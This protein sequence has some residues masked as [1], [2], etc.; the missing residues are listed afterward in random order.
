MLIIAAGRIV[1]SVASFLVRAQ[2]FAAQVTKQ[3]SV[4]VLHA[5][6]HAEPA[7]AVGVATPSPG[8]TS[9]RTTGGVHVSAE[10]LDIT[11]ASKTLPE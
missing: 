10:P 3:P 7:V 5:A 4:G 11:E 9:S 6:T 8:V 2:G 1:A